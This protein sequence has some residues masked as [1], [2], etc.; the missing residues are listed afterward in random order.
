VCVCVCVRARVQQQK[1]ATCAII[2]LLNVARLV[3][4]N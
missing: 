3:S 2:R 4:Q 1:T